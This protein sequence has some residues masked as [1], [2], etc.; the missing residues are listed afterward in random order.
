[1]GDGSRARIL[2]V[3]IAAGFLLAGCAS[4]GP[5]VAALRHGHWRA[6]YW[7]QH[8]A[9]SLE[10]GL[11]ALLGGSRHALKAVPMLLAAAS[12]VLLWRA[13]RRMERVS[14]LRLAAGDAVRPQIFFQA[15]ISR[16]AARI[17][18]V[19]ARRPDPGPHLRPSR[20]TARQD[21]TFPDRSR[22]I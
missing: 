21:L 14:L 4:S 15:R 20:G 16:R 1:M 10:P 11:V 22:S 17:S 3:V 9:G 13:G 18:R 6:F 8:Y 2:P 12:C 19:R 5:D 7:G